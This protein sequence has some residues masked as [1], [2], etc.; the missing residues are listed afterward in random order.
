MSK[1]NVPLLKRDLNWLSFNER[2]LQEAEDHKNPLYERLKF[3]AIFS[4]NLDEF[5]RVRV[6]RLRQIKSVDKQIRKKLALKP[7]KEVKTILKTVKKQQVRFGIIFN[8][9]II[10]ELASNNIYILSPEKYSFNQSA[11]ISEYFINKVFPNIN[12]R[13]IN[14]DEDKHPFLENNK[15]YFIVTFDESEKLGL[16]NIPVDKVGRF[17]SIPSNDPKHHITFI[18]DIIKN[19]IPVIFD[20]L[21]PKKCYQIKLSRDA[22]LYIDDEFD[23]V[24]AEKIK[25][26]LGKRKTGQPTRL[27]YDA[28]MPRTLAKTVRKLFDLGKID[29]MPGGKYHNFSDFFSFPDP[30][31]NASLHYPEQDVIKHAVLENSSS[32]FDILKRKDQMIHLPYMS[33]DYIQRFIS[34]AAVD[35]Y[36]TEIHISLYRIAE[37]SKLTSALIKALE[38]GKNVNVFVEAKARFDEEN[39]LKWGEILKTKGATVHYSYPKIKV[40][41]KI[42][43]IKRTENDQER[44][45]AY[46]GTGNF[47]AN[48][49]KFYCDHGLFTADERITTELNQVFNILSDTIEESSFNNLM[50]SPF[51]TRKTFEALIDTE[52]QNHKQGK[53]AFIKAK[54]NSLEDPK[55][56]SK[57]YEASK[58]G[59]K[60]DLVVRGF[61]RLAADSKEYS[62]NITAISILDRYLEHGRIYTFSNNNNPVTYIGSADWM[63]RNLDKRIEVLTPIYDNDLKDEINHILDLQLSDNIKARHHDSNGSNNYVTKSDMDKDIRSQ[64]EIPKFLKNIHQKEKAL[65][66]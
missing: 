32:Y 8:T 29:M 18:D 21:S 17:I 44:G 5:F 27:L 39:N 65:S 45:Y 59:V 22:E 60:I 49:S 42:L 4:S 9:T 53:P 24:L 6:S 23:G 37:E 43:L 7:S 2:V 10:P 38:N 58:A 30:T 50:V 26:S 1:D 46:I 34:Q 41:S 15:L 28:G 3:L 19:N 31:N 63:V 47:N 54:L 48:T 56:I 13:I 40:H 12:A 33:F 57:L 11:F 35:K 55:I 52:I 51:T 66:E 61:C 14:P 16:V 25:E 36:T 62:S 20:D 64:L